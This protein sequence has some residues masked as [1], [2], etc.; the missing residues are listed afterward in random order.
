MN[1]Y[2]KTLEDLI[3]CYKYLPGVGDKSAERFALYTLFNLDEVQIEDFSNALLSV[4]KDI[5]ICPSCG[6]ITMDD[7]C[8]ICKDPNRN[9]RQI[10]VLESI[11]DLLTIEKVNEFRGVYH[12]LNGAINFSKGITIDDLN[13]S[14]LTEKINN[15]EVDEL[16]LATN[17]TLEG[18]TTARYLKELYR[19]ND[20]KITRLA[21]GI[22][23]GG[24]LSYA[25]EMTILKSFQGRRDY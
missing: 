24:D 18:E 4:K 14:A 15:N 1:K 13:V 20:I 22:P 6:N 23:V 10:M 21:S 25:D 2:P 3:L 16:I 8:S 12:I 7:L 5:H 9:H 11:K 17:N 19:D